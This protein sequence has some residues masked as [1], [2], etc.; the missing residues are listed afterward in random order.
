M[1]SSQDV[2]RDELDQL[3]R[4]HD[5]R[6]LVQ[7]DAEG[8][9]MVYPMGGFYGDHQFGFTT[10]RKSQKVV[11]FERDPR[12]SF[13][14]VPS[15]VWDEAPGAGATAVTEE[16]ARAVVLSGKAEVLPPGVGLPEGMEM[17]DAGHET[18]AS[19]PGSEMHSKLMA[20]IAS[21][22]RAVV[23]IHAD[24]VQILKGGY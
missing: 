13:V 6:M 21:G 17:L 18:R 16:A 20:S 3:A 14:I 23:L 19:R 8:W 4:S 12:V 7:L 24:A 1:S 11:N 5:R 22:K 10:Y 2:S 15:E 9:P